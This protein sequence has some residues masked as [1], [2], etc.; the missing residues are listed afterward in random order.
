M[1]NN[2]TN[3]FITSNN[4]LNLKLIIYNVYKLHLERKLW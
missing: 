3:H 2:R 4:Y 1:V